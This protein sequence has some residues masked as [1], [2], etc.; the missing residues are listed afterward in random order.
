MGTLL[1]KNATAVCFD[2]PALEACDLRIA[3]GRVA[4]RA[5]QLSPLP[6]DEVIELGGKLLLPG[7]VCAHTHLYSSLARG[8]PAPK[9][10]PGNFHEILKYIW[11]RLDR[12][13]DEETI[14]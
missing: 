2:P 9:Q 3:S 1:L 7:L 13:L 8:M 14:Y 10:S 4:A 5:T 6:E 11:W 12:A